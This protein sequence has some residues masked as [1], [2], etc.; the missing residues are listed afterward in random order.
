MSVSRLTLLTFHEDEE[1]VVDAALGQPLKVTIGA[2]MLAGPQQAAGRDVGIRAL[3]PIE[4]VDFDVEAYKITGV[5]RFHA[6]GACVLDAGLSISLPVRPD[7]LPVRAGEF[8]SVRT[9]LYIEELEVSHADLVVDLVPR[10]ADIKV[11]TLPDFD[12]SWLPAEVDHSGVIDND[13]NPLRLVCDVMSIP[14]SP[15]ATWRG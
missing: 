5:L 6:S 1:Y 4:A 7:D 3:V 12:S 2:G 13:G 9:A 10:L 14:H 15:V 11:P 8:M